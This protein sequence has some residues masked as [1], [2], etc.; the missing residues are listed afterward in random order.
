[1][2]RQTSAIASGFCSRPEFFRRVLRFTSREFAGIPSAS[3]KV[4][5]LKLLRPRSVPAFARRKSLHT[6]SP[7]ASSAE[8]ILM[9]VRKTLRDVTP[10][11][12]GGTFGQMPERL[13]KFRKILLEV[14][15]CGE[16]P[17]VLGLE[18][19]VADLAHRAAAA[20][21]GCDMMGGLLHLFDAVRDRHR[22]T[23]PL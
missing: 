19:E 15:V 21:L 14:T 3:A 9:A 7:V 10:C 11:T 6:E 20:G 1:M 13:L 23:H 12:G 16:V 8:K 22:E 5:P 17:F 4:I 2:D 18:N